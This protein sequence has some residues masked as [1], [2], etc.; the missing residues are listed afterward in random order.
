MMQIMC[1]NKGKKGQGHLVL[2]SPLTLGPQTFTK[3]G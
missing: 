3:K 1:H 2:L